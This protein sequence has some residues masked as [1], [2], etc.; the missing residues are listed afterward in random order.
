[1]QGWWAV[2]NRQIGLH[3][4]RLATQYPVLTITG[5]RQSGKTTLAKASFPKAR[6]FSLEDPD[7]REY[8]T[9]D[10]RGFL[11]QVK[12]HSAIFDEVQKTPQ[13]ISYLQSVVDDDSRAGQFILTGSEQFELSRT[14]SQSLAGRTAVFR[15]LPF[16]YA[17]IYSQ[18]APPLDE[19]LYTGFY[20]R[21]HDRSLNPTQALSF[22][23]NTYIERDV[24]SLSQVRNLQQ[25]TL[26]LKLCAANVGQLMNKTRLGNDV[27]IDQKTVAAWLSIL[28]AS[29]VVF[30]LPPHF[31]NFRKRLVKSPKL[32]FYDAGLLCYLLGIQNSKH[33]ASHP[34]SGQLFENFV[35]MEY[36]K[37]CYN[38]VQD[39]NLYFFRDSKGTEVDLLLDHGA[40]ISAVEIK[41]GQTVNAAY[42]KGLNDYKKLNK[43]VITSS[44][45]YN[46]PS[47]G[48]Y[49]A[50]SVMHFSDMP[51]G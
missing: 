1:V 29:Y 14:I 36:L 28:Q 17:E 48:S 25:F 45:V 26:F 9:S 30:L 7:I 11:A 50:H 16:S 39:S 43:A 34:L 38:N 18:Q 31:K 22:Y 5:P 35:V 27:G 40:D 32:Y 37:S 12:G 13:L 4:K 42:F 20:P 2:I 21:I 8:A 33:V 23:T 47:L 10:P 6:Y 41:S 15:L 19:L 49:Y 46:G 51:W 24:R 44:L 3:L